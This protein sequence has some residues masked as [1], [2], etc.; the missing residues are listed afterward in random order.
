M[1]APP[2]P[3]SGLIWSRPPVEG[4]GNVMVTRVAAPGR[5]GWTVIFLPGPVGPTPVLTSVWMRES[6]GILEWLVTRV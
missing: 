2:P 3:P 4:L 6:R 1:D 5:P